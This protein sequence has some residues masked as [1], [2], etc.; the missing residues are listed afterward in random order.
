MAELIVNL[1]TST[2]PA[3]IRDIFNSLG[4][5]IQTYFIANK[6]ETNMV[7]VRNPWLDVLRGIAIVGV[8]SV[9]T[10]ETT[11]PIVAGL[12]GSTSNTFSNIMSLGQYGVEVFFFLSGWLMA[13]LY[14]NPSGEKNFSKRKFWARRIARIFPLYFVFLM[15][16]ILEDR[17]VGFGPWHMA[18]QLTLNNFS[19]NPIISILLT[20]TF[21][22]WI[23][24]GLWNVI[25]PGG[26]S[27]Q[28]EMG[29]YFLFA[30]MRKMTAEKLIKIVALC[31]VILAL[32]N[33][34]FELSHP[35]GFLKTVF[36]A[37]IR[38]NLMSTSFFF[39]LGIIT[40]K[41][42]V[43]KW[44]F[45]SLLNVSARTKANVIIIF[46]CWI[47]FPLAVG[48]NLQALGF[49]VIA[50]LASILIM[51]FPR[52]NEVLRVLGKYSYFIYFCHFHV[53]SISRYLIQHHSSALTPLRDSSLFTP[54]LQISMYLFF[55][56]L[57]ISASLLLAIPSY[58]YFEKPILKLAH[59]N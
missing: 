23:S 46:I 52:M 38:L 35:V 25:I 57:T 51:E 56:L 16:G 32:T 17:L 40:Q 37:I 10:I 42:S 11:D 3:T 24:L 13:A 28:V 29:H 7:Q 27:I 9:H 12:G 4:N 36:D 26:W 21:M 19:H 48:N 43:V 45:T 2:R 8:L 22:Q 59:K 53:L 30:Y 5:L 14:G 34:A 20:L 6:V 47:S 50:L 58:K 33:I 55:Y 39:L 15:L 44:E 41:R 1:D 49:L 31:Y 18:Q 54:Y